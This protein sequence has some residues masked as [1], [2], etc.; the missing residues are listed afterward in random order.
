MC[1]PCSSRK[2]GFPCSFHRIF[3]P[4]FSP[5]SR[6]AQGGRRMAP[7]FR[8]VVAQG[9]A[10]ATDAENASYPHRPFPAS[11]G[12][13]QATLHDPQNGLWRPW[14]GDGPHG[15]KNSLR[16]FF[17]C[18]AIKKQLISNGPV[19]HRCAA[20]ETDGRKNSLRLFFYC[21]AIKN[22]HFKWPRFS[23][24]RGN[25]NAWP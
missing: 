11:P 20:T 16:L 21:S 13:P 6:P 25:R 15:R 3:F 24:L 14:L 8:G 19:S 5:G 12:Q 23:P 1:A 9:T 10:G 17:Y 4:R 22:N 2:A 7:L 18:S